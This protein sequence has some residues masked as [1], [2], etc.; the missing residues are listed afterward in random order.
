MQL[1]LFL[2]QSEIANVLLSYRCK[3]NSSDKFDCIVPQTYLRRLCVLR[4][5]CIS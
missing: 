5:L 4:W 3:E 2:H 1:W